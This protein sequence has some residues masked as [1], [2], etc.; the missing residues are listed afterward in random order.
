[1][2]P[3]V[4]AGVSDE[5]RVRWVQNFFAGKRGEAMVVAVDGDRVVGFNQLLARGNA[6]VIDLIAVDPDHRKMGIAGDLIRFGDHHFAD[7]AEVRVSTQVANVT[8]CRLY[9]RMGFV[10]ASAQYVF[11]LHA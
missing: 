7:A 8:A 2:D 10:L 11:H 5:L 6:Y 4:P 3:A 9:E 1:L